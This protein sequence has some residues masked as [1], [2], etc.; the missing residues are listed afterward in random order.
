MLGWGVVH[1]SQ[2][3]S[4]KRLKVSCIREREQLSDSL[5]LQGD[6]PAPTLGSRRKN[7]SGFV[8]PLEPQPLGG[9]PAPS[10]STVG[11]TGPLGCGAGGAPSGSQ[12]QQQQQQQQQEQE[13]QQQQ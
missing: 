8:R 4:C 1:L 7:F 9:A 10:D 11:D 2:R 12:Q 13:Q 3:E 6:T 5:R